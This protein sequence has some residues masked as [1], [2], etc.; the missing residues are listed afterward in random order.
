[1]RNTKVLV[2]LAAVL[3]LVVLGVPSRAAADGASDYKAKCASCHGADGSGNTTVGKSMKIR[4]LGSAD[5]QKQ[6]DDELTKIISDGKGKMPAYKGK[7]DIAP[8]VKVI[9]GFKK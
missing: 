3:F 9:R 7:V 5:V 1:M 8:L 6:T 4:N 2:V